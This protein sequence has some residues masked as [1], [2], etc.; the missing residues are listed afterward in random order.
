MSAS[1]ISSLVAVTM[2]KAD[3]ANEDALHGADKAR[4]LV[5][6]QREARSRLRAF[7]DMV[8]DNEVSSG[9]EATIERMLGEINSEAGM[10]LDTNMSL[11]GNRQT[12]DVSDAAQAANAQEVDGVRSRFEDAIQDLESQDKMGNFEIQDLMAR[13]NQNQQLASSV[14]KKKDDTSSAVIGKV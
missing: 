3:Q 7:E 4:N 14:Q 8:R 6:S 10:S 9:D 2:L 12:G 1:G 13:F 5:T 11:Q